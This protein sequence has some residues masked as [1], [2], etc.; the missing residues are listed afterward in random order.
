MEATYTFESDVIGAYVAEDKRH[1]GQVCVEINNGEPV[2][3]V[4]MSPE[5]AIKLARELVHEAAFAEIRAV[6]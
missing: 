6:A 2:V 4:Y 5:E 1:A 3:V